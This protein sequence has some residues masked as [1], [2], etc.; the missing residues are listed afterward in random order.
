MKFSVNKHQRNFKRRL[1]ISFTYINFL[2][3]F[4]KVGK[5]A[6]YF[7][8]FAFTFLKGENPTPYKGYKS[9]GFEEKEKAQQQTI[10]Y[11]HELKQFG[12]GTE[13]WFL[14]LCQRV[15]YNSEVDLQYGIKCLRGFILLRFI[16]I[17]NFVKFK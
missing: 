17:L 14:S 13:C 6:G 1:M 4:T 7:H 16:E 10:S 11:L 9:L 15:R 3:K 12:Y 8:L 2:V 5:S